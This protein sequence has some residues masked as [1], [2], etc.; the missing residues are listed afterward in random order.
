MS[1]DDFTEYINKFHPEKV[2]KALKSQGKEGD[3]LPWDYFLEQIREISEVTI[4]SLQDT[5][6]QKSNCF[7]LFGFDFLVDKNLKLWLLEVNMSPAC[8]ERAD[9]LTE[10]LDDMSEGVLDLIEKKVLY[11]GEFRR[12]PLSNQA[13]DVEKEVAVKT[14]QLQKEAN[15][16]YNL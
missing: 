4:A 12:P 9:W 15:K 8:S 13:Y 11:G 6:K 1:S 5:I 10:M 16:N 14:Y 3:Q 2:R 7:E